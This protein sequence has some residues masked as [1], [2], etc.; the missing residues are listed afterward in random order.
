MEYLKV[1]KNLGANFLVGHMQI[2]KQIL[3]MPLR[4]LNYFLTHLQKNFIKG[5]RVNRNSFDNFF[6]FGMSI[7][8][9]MLFQK[10]FLK[11]MP[12]LIVFKIILSN[13][14]ESS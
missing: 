2:Y 1:S 4:I 12:N 13:V 7:F 8:E 3:L 9:S 11:S 6:S 14:E 10:I 5:K